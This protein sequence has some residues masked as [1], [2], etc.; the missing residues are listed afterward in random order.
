M[1]RP[2]V[3][4]LVAGLAGLILLCAGGV[5]VGI[6]V[7]GKA[8]VER[9]RQVREARQKAVEE[10]MDEVTLPIVRSVPVGESKVGTVTVNVSS[11]GEVIIR[12]NRLMTEAEIR[13]A[14]QK[15]LQAGAQTI[16]LRADRWTEYKN[17]D[18]V[19]RIGKDL[20]FAGIE[21]LVSGAAGGRGKLPLGDSQPDWRR[22]ESRPDFS[23]LVKTIRNGVND[24]NIS[25]LIAQ[26]GDAEIPL[27]G[28]EALKEYVTEA[29]PKL[30]N[31]ELIRIIPEAALKY[32][33]VVHVVEACVQSGFRVVVLAAPPDMEDVKNASREGKSA[34]PDV[35]A[36]RKIEQEIRTI[37]RA[38]Y[39]GTK[40]AELVALA[41]KLRQAA[42]DC[43]G[44]DA[45]VARYV[46]L[47]EAARLAAGGGDVAAA[48]EAVDEQAKW[49]E[50]NL[51]TE[52]LQA[53]ETALPSRSESVADAA[54]HLASVAVFAGETE[55]A[56]S[57]LK[58]AEK[59]A[60]ES[61]NAG[62]VERVNAR[63][64]EI[65]RL[66][67]A[68][69]DAKPP[70]NK[71]FAARLD[72]GR[73]GPKE[74]LLRSGGGNASS[75]AAVAAGL[76]W[77]IRHQAVD[78][79]WGMHDFHVHGKCNCAEPG[80]D[81]D[82]AGTALGLLPLLGAG[83][84]HK[85]GQQDHHA[86]AVERG[87]KWLLTRQRV[88][89]S[90][91]ADGYQHALATIAVCEAYGMTGDPALRQPAQKAI[92]AC[93]AWQHEDG[94]FRYRPR[95]PGDMS[96]HGWFVQALKVGSISGLNVPDATW[97]GINKFLDQ[98][99]T[100]DGSAYGY[101]Q[102]QPAPTVTAVGLLSR[103]YMGWGP[104]H[105]GLQKGLEYVR[106]LPPSPNF[107]NVYFY[108]YATPFVHSMAPANAEA[109]EQWN[110]K[111]R[112]LLIN[113]QDQGLNPDRRDQKGSWSPEG[114]AWGGQLGRLGH[115][116]FA[117]LT[118]EVY[119]RHLPLGKNE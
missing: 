117:L 5:I 40:P 106:K 115:T 85:G 58:L 34:V 107:K 118:L 80:G 87:L 73:R 93:V 74:E 3:V 69:P 76:K 23:L 25:A 41:G 47:R 105:P 83:E 89:G 116:S 86:K 75:E 78:G 54:L 38:D 9:Q 12:S 32:D 33:E 99:A 48:L 7:G 11:D 30:S 31:K 61:K 119:Y 84:T 60:Q 20:G 44:A 14:L 46:L 92:D 27:S 88:D 21:L 77:L 59:A 29:R 55:H 68:P 101:M 35:A 57:F 19:R 102:P 109:W 96:V 95:T 64:Q 6:F 108:Y 82:V 67:V 13:F 22:P 72:Q 45:T 111:M 112:D 90:F 62:L 39:A 53:L 97:S 8:L 98:C 114:D 37:Y 2:V 81:Y 43:A 103:H 104:R 91:P 17:V 70:V 4:F 15:E 63:R 110:L 1:K 56:E 49:Y 52:K 100:P 51:W 79:H 50:I 16:L 26:R 28:L 42:S 71:Y 24:G 36:Q 18:R 94:G 66:K 65:A 10:A 113:S